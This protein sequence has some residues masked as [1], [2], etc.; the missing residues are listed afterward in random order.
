MERKGASSWLPFSSL[1]SD[2]Q[3][4]H[5]SSRETA[6]KEDMAAEQ[7][8]TRS[9]VSSLPSQVLQ[10]NR[11]AFLSANWSSPPNSIFTRIWSPYPFLFEELAH[12]GGWW[13]PWGMFTSN[14]AN[15][16]QCFSFVFLI[17]TLL[18]VNLSSA[19]DY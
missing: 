7:R 9:Q 13:I 14:L 8:E 6:Q 4:L 1:R 19:C 12:R 15:H 17:D 11:F 16:I 18:F 3:R 2:F 5:P 10:T